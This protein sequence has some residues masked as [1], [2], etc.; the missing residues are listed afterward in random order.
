M[1]NRNLVSV[2]APVYNT[3][4]YLGRCIESVLHQSYRDIELLL[5]DDGST[6]NSLEICRHYQELDSRVRV[7]HKENGGVGSARNLGIA[8]M[9][10][11]FFLFL[12]SDDALAP[13]II[14]QVMDAY[15]KFSD[16]DMIA[17]GWQKIFHDGSTEQYLPGDALVTEIGSGIQTLLTNYNGYGGGYPNKLWRTAAFGGNVPKYNE[18]LFYFEDMEWMVRMFLAIHSFGC[19][20]SIGYLYYIRSDST[21]FRTDNAAR[22]EQGC[23]AS[24]QQIR[25]DLACQPELAAWFADRYYPEIVNGVLHAWKMGHSQLGRWLLCQM[26]RC[27]WEIL[28]SKHI[29]GKIKL[30]CAALSLLFW[31]R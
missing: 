17:F 4:P 12:D 6:D 29:S 31:I 21:T 26:R 16:A 10:G 30:R 1:K 20:D 3:S 8:Q 9:H 7:F 18:S 25:A 24:A 13:N 19:L 23:H 15:T 14:E 11:D 27:R 5:I 28:T 22:K 2:I